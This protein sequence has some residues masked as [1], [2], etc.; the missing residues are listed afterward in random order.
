MKLHIQLQVFS[1]KSLKEFNSQN[2]DEIEIPKERHI[3][4]EKMQ[5]I[6]DELRLV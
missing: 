2:E 5:Q 6:I 4:P 3:S 1:K